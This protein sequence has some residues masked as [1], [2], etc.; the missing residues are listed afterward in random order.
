VAG[1]SPNSAKATR[2]LKALL[3][4]H[5]SLRVGLEIV[6]VLRHPELAVR[7]NVIVTPTMLRL[8]PP[9]ARRIVGSLDDT[10]ALVSVLGLPKASA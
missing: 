4:A 10:D 5:P 8:S 1:E 2:N 3:A 7:D 9:P 6:D